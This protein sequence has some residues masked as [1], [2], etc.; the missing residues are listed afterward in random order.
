MEGSGEK[1]ET[2]EEKTVDE[3]TEQDETESKSTRFEGF[4]SRDKL[5]QTLKTYAEKL[6]YEEL[7]P[8]LT[9]KPEGSSHLVMRPPE[10]LSGKIIGKM[11]RW[12]K[13]CN[14]LFKPHLLQASRAAR[15]P[16][17][18]KFGEVR[19]GRKDSCTRTKIETHKRAT[20]ISTSDRIKM[21]GTQATEKDN[22]Q[23]NGSRQ[24]TRNR[25]TAQTGTMKAATNTHPYSE[26]RQ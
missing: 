7:H 2:V 23:R 3:K 20:P 10:K 15:A 25:P 4:A 13:K 5:V 6:P 22:G 26:D 21:D 16:P 8:E 11:A 18:R 17:D 9:W 14:Y 19:N 1:E 24:Q 12:R